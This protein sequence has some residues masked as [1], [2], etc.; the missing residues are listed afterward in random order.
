MIC[1]LRYNSRI[2]TALCLMLVSALSM[3]RYSQIVRASSVMNAGDWPNAAVIT[4]QD[5]SANLANQLLVEADKL[6]LAATEESRRTA[7]EKYTT[8]LP[9][10]HNLGDRGK[11]ATTLHWLCSTHNA[12][13]ER[14]R[15]LS[16]CEQAATIR[17]E[18]NDQRGEAESLNLIGTIQL[19]LHGPEPA[20]EP[21]QRSLA[22]RR[23]IGDQRGIAVTLGNLA[24]AYIQLGEY[25]KEMEALQEALPLAQAAKDQALENN[26]LNQIASAYGGFGQMEMALKYNQQ[27]LDLSRARKDQATEA[28]TLSNLG[29]FYYETGAQQRA[30][31]T[32]GEALALHRLIGNRAAEAANLITLAGVRNSLGEADKALPIGEDALK[33]ARESGHF[34]YEFYALQGL[35][36]TCHLLG[37]NRKAGEYDQAALSLA[38]ARGSKQNEALVLSHLAL[39]WQRSGDLS[40]AIEYGQQAIALHRESGDRAE[41][42]YALHEL[43]R[44][45]SKLKAYA[46]ATAACNE[47]LDLSRLRGDRESQAKTLLEIG[48]IEARQGNRSQARN[49]FEEALRLFEALS[50]ELHSGTSRASFIGINYSAYDNYIELLIKQHRENPTDALDRQAF[51]AVERARART[52]LL[53]LAEVRAGIRQGV[54]PV[55]LGREQGVLK[56]LEFKAVEQSRLGNIGANQQTRLSSTAREITELYGE[57]EQVRGQIRNNSPRYA[58]LTQPQPLSTS[59]IQKEVV[60]NNDTLLLEYALGEEQSFLWTVSANSFNNYE[61][62]KG[63]IIEKAAQRVYDLLTVRNQKVDFEDAEEKRMRFKQADADFQIAAAEL[64][65]LILS[66]VAA[67]LRRK[68]PKQLL[69][70]A[71]GK[72]QYVPFAALPLPVREG[73]RERGKEGQRANRPVSPSLRLSIP[74]VANYEIVN[75]PSAST[76]AV[77][78]R[79]LKDRKPAPKTLAIF[80]D[81]V[82]E[83]DDERVPKDVR[84]RLE[85]ERQMPATGKEKSAQALTMPDEL[86]RA[87]TNIGLDGTRGKLRRLPFS[88][89]EANA[90]L[91]FAPADGSFSALDFDATQEAALKP[92]LSQYRYVHFATHGFLDNVTPELSGLVLSQLDAKGHERDGYLRMVEIINMNLPAELVVLS[93]CK[94]GLGK[95]VRGEGLMSLTRGFMYAGAARVMV[96]LWDVND[97]STSVLMGEFYQGLLQQKLRPSAALRAAQLKMLKS[98]QWAS[99]Y[100]WAAF[101]QL[102]EPR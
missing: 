47:S 73:T 25:Q 18:L 45:H 72:L 30:L 90:I 33:L 79:E 75:L 54:D 64:S 97:K 74:L 20:L 37:E 29:R 42:M 24:R 44:A 92:D 70:V 61:L 80:A 11:E 78:R 76:L 71:D 85:R 10:W 99:P 56:R 6:R 94:T 36:E 84:D 66:P 12:L 58:A 86:T 31:D 32:L 48:K 16:Y 102:G 77:L 62:P 87:L 100:Y 15:A 52:L 1:H 53:M 4:A 67:E 49:L 88:R 26:L 82:F 38:R 3:A 43:C 60:A 27:S 91:K 17:R 9:L 35:G 69:I 34:Q 89:E 68:R 5:S 65:R 2:L 59:Q 96:S 28:A 51:Q 21:Y 39:D 7:I 14:Q 93:A 8:A 13:L 101:V 19:A 41:L 83:P 81:P 22:L 57:L 46:V 63:E 95:E 23:T 40:K 50:S 55:L 98:K